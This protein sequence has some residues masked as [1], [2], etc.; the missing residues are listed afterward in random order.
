MNNFKVLQFKF[1]NFTALKES[2]IKLDQGIPIERK[3]TIFESIGFGGFTS[4]PSA[5]KKLTE[6]NEIFHF[7]QF[8]FDS[9]VFKHLPQT[10]YLLRN[11]DKLLTCLEIS[12]FSSHP[13][14]QQFLKQFLES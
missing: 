14:D 3:K 2:F 1:I 4:E 13:S 11:N 9:L 12:R 8:F 10:S 6:I 7:M 5:D